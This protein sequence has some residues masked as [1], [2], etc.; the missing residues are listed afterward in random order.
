MADTVI[1]RFTFVPERA[2]EFSDD[3]RQVVEIALDSVEEVQEFTEQFK[4]ALLD[5]TAIVNGQVV[6]LSDFA[7]TN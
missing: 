6:S 2:A 5:V 1:T 4:D 3:G 7:G